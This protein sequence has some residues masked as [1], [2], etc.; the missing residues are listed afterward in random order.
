MESFQY[1]SHFL[2]V[3]TVKICSGRSHT[4]E[5]QR[6]RQCYGRE[7]SP[8]DEEKARSQKM[9]LHVFKAREGDKNGLRVFF[10]NP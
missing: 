4:F 6:T 7:L 10:P 8:R 1:S 2:Q 5:E 9:D 3:K